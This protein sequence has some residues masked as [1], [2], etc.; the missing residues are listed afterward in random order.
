M[1]ER[2][3][4]DERMAVEFLE[5]HGKDRR[6]Q[7]QRKQGVPSDKLAVEPECWPHPI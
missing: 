7:D 3:G 2:D 5:S 1:G 4:Q 6:K